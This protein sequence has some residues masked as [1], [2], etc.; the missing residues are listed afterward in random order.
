MGCH[1][2][3]QGNLPDSGMESGSH[4]LQ[5]DSLPSEPPREPLKVATVAKFPQAVRTARVGEKA[6]SCSAVAASHCSS[7][8][9]SRTI[10][11][12]RSSA[13][14]GC[15]QQGKQIYRIYLCFA[16]LSWV[17]NLAYVVGILTA[18]WNEVDMASSFGR[19]L[20]IFV[21][22]TLATFR[23]EQLDLTKRLGA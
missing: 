3:L 10:A 14:S 16:E 18:P 6:G 9:S 11:Y 13:A 21:L 17:R 5:A 15:P 4:T 20:F 7:Q 8:P 22:P 2:L 19:Q 1:S 12:T 23:P